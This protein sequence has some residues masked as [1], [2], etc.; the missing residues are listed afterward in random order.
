MEGASSRY[1]VHQ[2]VPYL[3]PLGVAC[4]VQPFMDDAMY[5]LSFSPGHTLRKA[6][7]TA[8]ACWRRL[9]KLRHAGAYDIVYLQRELFPFG[10]PFFERLLKQRGAVLFF[11]YDDALFIKKPSRYNPLATVLRS[12]G[13]TFTLFGLVDCVVA[14]NNWLRDRAR[15]HGACA[16]TLDVAEDTQ[17]IRMHAPHTN[18][19]PVTIGWLGS[20]STVKYLREIEPVLQEVARR[21]PG[22]RFEV[23]GGGE[24]SQAGV[25]WVV[26][27]WSLES[28]LEALARFDIGLM[29]LPNEDWAKGKSGG[30]A[31]TYMTA[32][33]VP[34]CAGIGYNLEL[35][36]DGETGFLCTT[37]EQWL[38]RICSAIEDAALRQ[39]VAT[40]ARHDVEQR[41]SLTGQAQKMRSLFDTV[42]AAKAQGNPKEVHAGQ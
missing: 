8:R 25:P 3:E 37:H 9:S 14:G 31:R 23:V 15:E 26:T 13:K 24:F 32:G 10:P 29:P 28:E 41:F 11:D 27:E 18:E 42:L 38:D 40:N 4:D 33:V 19:R 12:A 36:R 21:Y 16:V 6:W 30:K 35:I 34:I 7:A 20:K 17:R 22:V 1:R 2:Y 5:R 39:R